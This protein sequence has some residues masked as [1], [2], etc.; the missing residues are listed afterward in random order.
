MNERTIPDERKREVKDRLVEDGLKTLC[1]KKVFLYGLGSRF[2]YYITELEDTTDQLRSENERLRL[3]E[4][5]Y[6]FECDVSDQLTK[7]RDGARAENERI[8]ARCEKLE[9]VLNATKKAV[10]STPHRK[11]CSSRH[12][13][14]CVCWQAYV[15]TALADCEVDI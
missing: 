2:R 4:T 3:I 11:E 1:T 5:D 8:K 12:G 7:E 15:K 6:K 14:H 10:K 13:L 9:H